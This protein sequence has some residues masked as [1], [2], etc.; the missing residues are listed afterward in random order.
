MYHTTN[1]R[2]AAERCD[3]PKYQT[4][5]R[6]YDNKKRPRPASRNPLPKPGAAA[7]RLYN[8]EENATECNEMQQILKDLG[9]GRVSN[10]SLPR[11]RRDTETRFFNSRRLNSPFHSLPR[12]NYNDEN[13][14]GCPPFPHSQGSIPTS[15]RYGGSG[16]RKS[17]SYSISRSR[18]P[19]L[20]Y[21]DR[22]GSFSQPVPM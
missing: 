15:P 17:I 21:S 9:H 12:P 22:A 6:C 5:A 2:P 4:V 20:T 16:R 14:T 18:K 10:P 1:G 13:A 8:N 19:R 11:R 3:V 7:T